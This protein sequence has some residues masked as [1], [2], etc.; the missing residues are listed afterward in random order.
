M[1]CV[2]FISTCVKILLNYI[3]QIREQNT[4]WSHNVLFYCKKLK[5]NG[6]ARNKNKREKLCV[7]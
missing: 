4:N 3:Q 7:A 6:F 5:I 2:E 1:Y